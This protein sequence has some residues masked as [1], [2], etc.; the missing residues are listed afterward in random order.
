MSAAGLGPLLLASVLFGAM[1]VCVQ[2]AARHMGPVQ[3]A[4]VR[5]AGS[6]VVLLVATRARELWPRSASLGRLVLRGLLGAMSISCY[7]AGI[8]RAGAGLATLLFG[9]YP[10]WTA[11]W[12]AVLHGDRL[13][14]RIVAALALNL[15]GAVLVLGGSVQL[16]AAVE[17]GAASALLGGVL[18]GGAVATASHLRRTESASLVTIHFMAVG[19][20]LTAP[21]LVTGLPPLSA[22]LAVALVGVVLTS[23]GGQWLLHH[24]LGY[25]SATTASLAAAT[26]VVTAACL[27]ALV[28][29]E[30]LDARL[31]VAAVCMLLAIALAASGRPVAAISVAESAD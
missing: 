5:F 26:S 12:V 31:A 15:L 3:V 13:T 8:S 28:V 29:G 24:G 22:P 7:Y 30:Q 19:A 11:V 16:G 18:A 14:G 25:V 10:V 23:V 27:Q 17:A 2:L 21:S 9:T 4:C 6:F 1:A 20:I